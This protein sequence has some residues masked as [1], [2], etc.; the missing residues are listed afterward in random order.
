VNKKNILIIV[1]ILV[2]VT[3]LVAYQIIQKRQSDEAADTASLQMVEDENYGLSF[4]YK[5]GADGFTLVEPPAG[6]VGILKAYLLL[7]SK[8]YEEYKTREVAGEAPA[9]MNIFVFTMDENKA[10][11]TTDSAEDSTSTTTRVDR[12]D[13]LK[14]WATTNTTITSY[15]AAKAAPETMEIDG[16]TMLRYKA[17]GLYQQDVYLGSYKNRAYMFVGQYNEE[18][19]QT[20]TAFQELMK[21]VSFD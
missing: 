20:F 15:A 6:Q 13:R 19:D 7:P 9:G 14:E 12:L 5:G 10:A 8:A 1:A 17:D 11:T 18:S 4:S 21:T 2:L 16:L 3:A